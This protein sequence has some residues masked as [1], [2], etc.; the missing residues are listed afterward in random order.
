MPLI[1]SLYSFH[2]SSDYKE[3]SIHVRDY[4]STQD[5]KIVKP[6]GGSYELG[7]LAMDDEGH[8]L[9]VVSKD[10]CYIYL[11][12]LTQSTER[13][14]KAEKAEKSEKAETTDKQEK[15]RSVLE[16]KEPI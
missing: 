1:A 14:E 8:R 7:G 13:N 4:A 15:S 12:V 11:Y 2:S 10:A 6:F 5:L 3:D 9:A 16:L